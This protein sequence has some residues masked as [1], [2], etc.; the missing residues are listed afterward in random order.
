MITVVNIH[1]VFLRTKQSVKCYFSLLT[2]PLY[3]ARTTIIATLQMRNWGSE[4]LPYSGSQLT[5]GRA[6][7]CKSFVI[8]IPRHLVF[9]HCKW[10][11]YFLTC[12]LSL[13]FFFLLYRNTSG[14]CIFFRIQKIY[15]YSFNGYLWNFTISM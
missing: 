5:A 9:C 7:L 11:L 12:F 3:L 13:S 1:W 4:K 15:I 14:S 10:C 6:G 2:S 8:F